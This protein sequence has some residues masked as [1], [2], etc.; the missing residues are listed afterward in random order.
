MRIQIAGRALEDLV[1]RHDFNHERGEDWAG[2][3]EDRLF[4]RM[5]S[6]VTTPFTGRVTGRSG[7]R[8]LSVPD[9]QYVIDYRVRH[10]L[11]QIL[12]I[13]STREMR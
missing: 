4:E 6:L 8:R 10:D 11:V 3:V 2:R 1:R 5:N 12:R 7:V 13:R 9:I